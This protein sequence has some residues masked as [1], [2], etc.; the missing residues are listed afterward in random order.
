MTNIFYRIKQLF[1][2]PEKSSN[3]Q[4]T[5]VQFSLD[6]DNEP[7]VKIT[8]ADT[9]NEAADV[10]ASMLDG[11]NHGKYLD[12]VLKILVEIGSQDKEINSFVKR[13]FNKWSYLENKNEQDL[14]GPQV[15]P[16]DFFKGSKHGT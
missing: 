12:S 7:H 8:I 3:T 15:K 9:S 2:K 13:V 11:I 14:L 6:R 10:F 4:P 16:T 1:V 5:S